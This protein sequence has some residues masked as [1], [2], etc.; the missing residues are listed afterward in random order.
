M[1]DIKIK[2]NIVIIG[3]GN[4]ATILGRKLK[5][6]GHVIIQVYGRNAK[7]VCK[8]ADELE[9]EYV[10]D[11]AVIDRTADLY[12]IAVSDVAVKEVIQQLELNDK[13]VVHTAAS[14]SKDILNTFEA[15]WS[16]LSFANI[17]KGCP[18]SSANS[19]LS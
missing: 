18:S 13:T 1:H 19:L 9:T 15:L 5:E 4:T 6:A 11:L 10:S 3:T 8:L 17:E 12:L 16:I 7:K 2:M 14:V